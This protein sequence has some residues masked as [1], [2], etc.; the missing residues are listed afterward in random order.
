MLV[1]FAVIIGGIIA[2]RQLSSWRLLFDNRM[3]TVIIMLLQ[4]LLGL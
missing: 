4:I 3:I 2:G 1:I